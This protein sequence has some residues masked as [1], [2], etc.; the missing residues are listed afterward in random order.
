VAARLARSYLWVEVASHTAT[1]ADA[2]R[3]DIRA[4]LVAWRNVPL[5]PIFTLVLAAGSVLTLPSHDSLLILLAGLLL[6]FVSFGWFGTQFIWYQRAFDG[7]PIH[8]RELFPLTWSFIARY[9]RLYFLAL[10]P[11]F[12]FVFAAIRWHSFTFESPGWRIGVLLY[13][14]VFDVSAT[15]INPALAF[16]TRKVTS[17]I[18]IGLRMII[19]GWPRNWKYVVVPGVA[20]AV[21]GGA[22]WLVPPPSRPVP[23][24]LITLISLVFAGAI[25]R[26]YLRNPLRPRLEIEP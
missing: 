17:A 19:Q 22:Y 13:I 14:L 4:S 16:S 12:V 3:D 1:I 11:L 7:Q 24:I 8:K 18:P 26:Y 6:G 10:I 23:E 15:F 2:F 5:L 20:G 25:A 9:V 21:L